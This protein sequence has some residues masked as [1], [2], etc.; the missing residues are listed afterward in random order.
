MI[1]GWGKGHSLPL[2]S[3]CNTLEVIPKRDRELAA[4]FQQA[5]ERVTGLL[6]GPGAGLAIDLAFGDKAADGIVRAVGVQR[7]VGPVEHP[8][9][10]VFV[11][12]APSNGLVELGE[13]GEPAENP[14]ETPPQRRPTG[15]ARLV[16][17]ELQVGVEPPDQRAL[18]R[19]PPLLLV[20]H[21]HDPAQVSLR[22]DPT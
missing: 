13:A 4:G 10:I 20:G 22:R 3:P 5:E 17:V 1:N 12:V 18:H 7:D 14:I 2:P 6:A 9:Q 19:D 8:E 16:F 11:G 15:R 21:A